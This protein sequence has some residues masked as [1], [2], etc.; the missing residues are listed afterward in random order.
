MS[1][2]ERPPPYDS[3][4]SIQFI[5]ASIAACMARI[6][7]SSERLPH[8]SPPASHVPRPITEILGPFDPSLRISM[9]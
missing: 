4:V 7:S 1:S 8:W 5:P 3:A 2:S 6:V 9:A